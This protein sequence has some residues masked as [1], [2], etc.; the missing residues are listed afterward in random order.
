[1]IFAG[2]ANCPGRNYQHD[3]RRVPRIG[4]TVHFRSLCITRLV[5]AVS[6]GRS[7]S[8]TMRIETVFP[9]SYFSNLLLAV[10]VIFIIIRAARIIDV[11]PVLSEFF[12][13]AILLALLSATAWSLFSTKELIDV[14]IIGGCCGPVCDCCLRRCWLWGGGLI[15]HSGLDFWRWWRDCGFWW[16]RLRKFAGNC[17]RFRLLCRDLWSFGWLES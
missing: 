15:R 10:L 1:L 16:R 17:P 11:V 3:I 2:G 4:H 6:G 7:P 13:C 5:A 12:S 14:F 9:L 8:R